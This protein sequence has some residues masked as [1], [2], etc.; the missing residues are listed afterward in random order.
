MDDRG[1]YASGDQSSDG[2]KGDA[3]SVVGEPEQGC[4]WLLFGE[5]DEASDIIVGRAD[6]QPYAIAAKAK[7]EVID[8]RL[9]EKWIVDSGCGHDLVGRILVQSSRI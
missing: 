5:A 7:E 1:A 8:H 3:V 4:P 6:G 9:V 2:E